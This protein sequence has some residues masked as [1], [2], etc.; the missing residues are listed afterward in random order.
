MGTP[1]IRDVHV[2]KRWFRLGSWRNSLIL[3]ALGCAGPTSGGTDNP[4]VGGSVELWPVGSVGRLPGQGDVFVEEATQ[5][6]VWG[7]SVVM[8]DQMA[9]S[10]LVH[11]LSAGRTTRL[12]DRS[13]ADPAQIEMPFRVAVSDDGSIWIGDIA[14]G[15]VRF[16]SAADSVETIRIQLP[17]LLFGFAVSDVFGAIGG[18][19]DSSS[20]LTLLT[21]GGGPIRNAAPPA[22]GPEFDPR[23]LINIRFFLVNAGPNEIL[24]VDAIAVRMWRVT[25]ETGG[26]TIIRVVE[27][28]FPAWFVDDVN[29]EA[30]RIVSAFDRP[31]TTISIPRIKNAHPFGDGGIWLVP[32][33]ATIAGMGLP[34]EGGPPIVAWADG[35][36]AMPRD[37]YLR[38][39]T[40]FVLYPTGVDL[41]RVSSDEGMR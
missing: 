39:D 10:I 15:V 17:G 30:A 34:G 7:D 9:R 18:P 40:L 14:R 36:R 20:P 21:D 24:L 2:R 23:S 11:S 5:F 6:S 4:D 33:S 25:L 3:L 29:A 41:V 26:P 37:S 1:I 13:G 8:I 27:I 16:Y 32:V 19:S 31:G 12:G 28:Q 22:T 38:G 35:V